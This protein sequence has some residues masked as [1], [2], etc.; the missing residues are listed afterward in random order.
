M[1]CDSKRSVCIT[2]D[3]KVDL[4]YILLRDSELDKGEFWRV[5]S[6]LPGSL[7]NAHRASERSRKI[8]VFASVQL[9]LAVIKWE[10]CLVSRHRELH[11]GNDE[12]SIGAGYK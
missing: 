11:R 1:H 4:I 5:L 3:N 9:I 8:W 10:N 6:Q 7:K 12:T 2:F